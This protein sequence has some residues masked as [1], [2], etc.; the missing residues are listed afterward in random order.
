VAETA[1]LILLLRQAVASLRPKDRALVE[2]VLAGGTLRAAAEAIGM[3]Y[4]TTK[5]RWRQVRA[6]L[7]ARLALWHEP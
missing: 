7:A 4:P 2:Q 3:P 5:C 6:S 1:E